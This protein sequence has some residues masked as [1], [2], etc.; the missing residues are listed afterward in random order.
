MEPENAITVRHAPDNHCYELVDG[1]TSIGKTQY[2]APGDSGGER[3]FYHT[4]VSDDYAGK[5]L[6]SVLVKHALNDTVAAGLTI[7]P[8]CPYVKAWL[9]RHPEYQQHAGK[10]RPE[11][12]AAVDGIQE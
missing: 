4:E 9:R 12:F 5:G 6:A 7:I 11:H 8:V 1:Q 10:V 3:I 2:I